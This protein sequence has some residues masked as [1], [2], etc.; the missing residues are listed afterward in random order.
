[1]TD[2]GN[3]LASATEG[4]RLTLRLASK[5]DGLDELTVEI[6]GSEISTGTYSDRV[7]VRARAV[8]DT[9][10]RRVEL[11][12]RHIATGWAEPRIV[13][14]YPDGVSSPERVVVEATHERRGEA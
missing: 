7:E 9:A 6:T 14:H 5:I 4:D 1:M 8:S 10:V 11:R 3:C 13:A 2:S 12:S